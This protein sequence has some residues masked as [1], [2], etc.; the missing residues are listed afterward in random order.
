[1]LTAITVFLFL[2][3]FA[4][5]ANEAIISQVQRQ[6]QRSFVAA[7]ALVVGQGVALWGHVVLVNLDPVEV[8]TLSS[9]ARLSFFAT[10][11]QTFNNGKGFR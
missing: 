9:P 8:L 6:D 5:T 2:T 10:L 4:I 7:V 3:A 11:W 1:M